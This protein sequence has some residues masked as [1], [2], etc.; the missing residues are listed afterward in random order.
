MV[1]VEPMADVVPLVYLVYYVICVL[2]G[3][4]SEDSQFKI[5]GEMLK[6]F[7][8]VGSNMIGFLGGVEV[9]ECFIEVKDEEV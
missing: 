2:L 1:A 8:S 9:D 4:C 3:S 7:R 6:E 5:L